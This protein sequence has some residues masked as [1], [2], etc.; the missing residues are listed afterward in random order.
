MIWFEP[1]AA[2]VFARLTSIRSGRRRPSAIYSRNRLLDAVHQAIV[3]L[4]RWRGLCL[5][6]NLDG[7]KW[8]TNQR[9]VDAGGKT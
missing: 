5:K 7:L 2:D 9:D 3:D 8:V 6:A 4:I 1:P